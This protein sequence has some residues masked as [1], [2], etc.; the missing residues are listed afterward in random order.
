VVGHAAVAAAGIGAAAG[1]LYLNNPSVRDALLY[2]VL[3]LVGALPIAV[4]A[5]AFA[6][7]DT[8]TAARR[9]L[10]GLGSLGGMP[11]RDQQRGGR[12]IVGAAL[13]LFLGGALAFVLGHVA[14]NVMPHLQFLPHASNANAEWA[15]TDPDQDWAIYRAQY[16]SAFLAHT[17]GTEADFQAQKHEL[18]RGSV[19]AAR[20]LFGFAAI[21][22]AAGIVDLGRRRRGRGLS[23]LIVGVG[24]CLVLYT[25]WY[26][27]EGHYAKEMV[28][29]SVRLPEA[30]RPSLPDSAPEGL[31]RLVDAR[32]P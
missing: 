30:V 19:R 12:W 1:G 15:L 32:R 2:E 25:L 23:S 29:A 17:R 26:L 11:L 6:G 9:L 20:T 7:I 10:W 5:A 21:L 24:A 27:R 18:G 28:A 8:G 13:A 31:Q 14:D 4:L 22:V 16:K 3:A